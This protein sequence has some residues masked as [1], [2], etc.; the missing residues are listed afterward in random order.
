MVEQ[1]QFDGIERCGQS[2]VDFFLACGA[3]LWQHYTIPIGSI[4]SILALC[5]CR[6]SLSTIPVFPNFDKDRQLCFLISIQK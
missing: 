5:G 1:L 6:S 3:V 2:F 4:L